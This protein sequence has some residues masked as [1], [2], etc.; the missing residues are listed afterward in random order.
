MTH[1]THVK[2]DPFDPLTHE[3]STHCL[4]CIT[5]PEVHSRLYLWFSSTDDELETHGAMV[6]LPGATL[7]DRHQNYDSNNSKSKYAHTAQILTVITNRAT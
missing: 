2:S 7:Y 3:P 5:L 1:V 4:L 6:A